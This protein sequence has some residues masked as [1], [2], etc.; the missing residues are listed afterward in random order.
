VKRP[1]E[2]QPLPLAA[3]SLYHQ[4]HPLKLATDASTA[5]ASLFLLAAHRLP[6]ALVVMF[7][8]PILASAL[9]LRFADFSRTH[10]SRAG[11]YL[12]RYMTP[13]MQVV[14]LLGMAVASLGAW[15][16]AWLLLPLGAT[17][18]AWGWTGG[19]LVDRLGRSQ[20]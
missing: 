8:P 11:A 17:I 14:R 7:L 2:L 15:Q 9:L 3:R 10:D 6:L 12:R 18:I 19:W 1:S 4:L 13:A 16:H 20:D 5:V